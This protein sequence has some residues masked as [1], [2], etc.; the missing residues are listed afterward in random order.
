MSIHLLVKYLTA[1]AGFMDSE[2]VSLLLM[3]ISSHMVKQL[4][5]NQPEQS[6]FICSTDNGANFLIQNWMVIGQ[7]QIP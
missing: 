6:G 2:I 4:M 5:F 7:V 1:K 3:P